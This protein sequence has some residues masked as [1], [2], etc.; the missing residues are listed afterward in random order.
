MHENEAEGLTSRLLAAFPGRDVPETTAMVFIQAFLRYRLEVGQVAV[1]RLVE[2]SRFVPPEGELLDELRDAEQA[3]AA[4]EG[5]SRPALP[6]EGEWTDAE[7]E[8]ARVAQKRAF[9]RWRAWKDHQMT[10]ASRSPAAFR[11]RF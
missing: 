11:K 5:A 7:R 9:E 3:R 6:P 4:A 2:R 8:R 10:E 1:R